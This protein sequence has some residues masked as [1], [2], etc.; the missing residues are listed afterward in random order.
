M[1]LKS[2]MILEEYQREKAN[3][4]T[5]GNV[6]N[7]KLREMIKENHM[8]VL[9]VEHRVKE[10]QSLIGKLEIKGDK[11]NSLSEITDILGARVVSFFCDDVDEI[12]MHIEK[13]FDVDWENSVDKRAQLSP[14]AFGYL[15]LHYICSL[16]SDGQYPKEI[17]DKKFEIQIRSSLQHT[18]SSINHDL[19]Y[20]SE[21]GVP[22]DIVREFS[23]IAGLLEIADEQFAHIKKSMADYG[24][25][26][27]KRIADDQAENLGIDIVS[28]N[29][30]VLSNKKMR[31]FLNALA[32]ICGAEISNIDPQSYIEQLSW[33][34]MK[35]LGDLQD[36]L[37]RN[38]DTALA[39]AEC[40]LRDTE[41]DILSS[42][43]GLR[44]LCRAELLTKGY[45]NEQVAEFI[46]LSTGDEARAKRQAKRLLSQYDS[47]RGEQA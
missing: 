11:Y 14:D 39:L 36:M 31:K 6:V 27:R 17:C 44:F 37:K 47:L 8:N 4:I 26:V 25:D 13:M 12:A 29:E 24:H 18:W 45:T 40:S 21:F 23:R 41:L 20:K 22:R 30:Y 42:T 28:L 43:V 15:S 46:F 38:E 10:E 32:A 7:S 5:L 33:L 34:G 35:T 3:F 9:A 16:P 1:N 2:K 19:G